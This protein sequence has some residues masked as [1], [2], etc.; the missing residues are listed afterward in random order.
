MCVAVSLGQAATIHPVTSMIATSE[1]VLFP[2]HNQLLTTVTR[3]F[4]R[5]PA[6]IKMSGH[7]HQWLAGGYDLAV[8]YF[9]KWL[10][11]WLPGG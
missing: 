4:A 2:G 7:Q 3:Y 5:V 10:A 1:K 11:W 6:I 9:E 8:G